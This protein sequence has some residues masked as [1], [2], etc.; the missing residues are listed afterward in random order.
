MGVEV[1]LREVRD[2]DFEVLYENQLDPESN[3]M[4]GVE[5]RDREGFLAHRS[6]IEADPETITQVIA[7]DGVDLAGDIGSWRTKEGVREVGYRIGKAFWGRGIATA[8]LAAFVAEQPGRALYA[9]VIRH[10]LGSIR[11]LE[12]CGFER[13]ADGDGPDPDPEADEFVLRG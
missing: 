6:R 10:N 4:A 9:H 7:V 3:A 11:V 12:K 8:A 5:P 13:L 2:E 1:R